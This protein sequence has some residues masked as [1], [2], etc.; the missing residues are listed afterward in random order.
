MN[1]RYNVFLWF[2]LVAALAWSS[3]MQIEARGLSSQQGPSPSSC[4]YRSGRMILDLELA[5]SQKCFQEILEQGNA[6]ENARIV[7]IN[8]Y[9][10]TVFVGLYWAVFVL[11]AVTFRGWQSRWVVLLISAAAIFDLLENHRILRGL[12]AELSA[13]SAYALTPRPFSLVKWIVFAIASLALAALLWS[14]GDRWS[15]LVSAALFSSGL[16]TVAGLYKSGLMKGVT[17]LF[18]FAFLAA[19]LRYFPWKLSLEIVLGWIEYAYLMRFQ[20]LFAGILVA[21]LPMAYWAAPSIFEGLFDGRGFRS[22]SLI[23]W[24]AFQLAWTVMAAARLVLAYG[25]DR[26]ARAQRITMR[27][28]QFQTVSGFGLLAVPLIAML[29]CGTSE[30]EVGLAAKALAT[31]LGALLALFVLMLTAA[32]HF[33]IE[34]EPGT[35]ANTVFPNFGFLDHSSIKGDQWQFWR[36]VDTNLSQL[37]E[38]LMAG[39]VRSGRLRSGHEMAVITVGILLC[40][41]VLTGVVFSPAWCTPERQP[42]ALFYLLFLV[43]LLTWVFSGAAFFLDRFRFPGSHDTSMRFLIDGFC[44]DRPS[45]CRHENR[46][47]TAAGTF[48]HRCDQPLGTRPKIRA[49]QDGHRDCNRRR[50]DSGVRVDRRGFHPTR[51]ALRR[52]VQLFG[53]SGKFGFWGKRWVDVCRRSLQWSDG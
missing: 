8:T 17:P 24:A 18:A 53:C 5:S 28:P 46:R 39:I 15:R 51:G 29:W 37:S 27:S 31:A 12:V 32:L 9:M 33:A 43:T 16:L 10:D 25:P 26:F 14:L 20:I 47:D 7:R 36:R 13:S 2:A 30:A 42:A 38:D 4:S 41:Y 34:E 6:E 19:L 44:P 1:N 49:R 21:G 48:T 11:F 50:R 40:L 35:T 45:V 22:F 23:S 52:G 3:C